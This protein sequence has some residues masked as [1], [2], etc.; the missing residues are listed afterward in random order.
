[1]MDYILKVFF[2]QTLHSN[3]DAGVS[4]AKWGV[5]LWFDGEL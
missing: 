3:T 4:S 5:Y 2:Y 1:M